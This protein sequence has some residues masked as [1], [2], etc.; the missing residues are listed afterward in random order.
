MKANLE[1][2]Y[3]RI[4]NQIIDKLCSINLSSYENRVL[5]CVIRKTYGF[6]KKEDWIANSQ[7]VKQTSIHKAHVSRAIKKLK[8]R[9]IVT[10]T[11]NLLKIN[12]DT[13]SW[14]PNQVTKKKLPKEATPLPNQVTPVTS[15]GY[16]KL[17]KEADTKD[18]KDTIT[19]DTIQKTGDSLQKY[20]DSFNVFF[21]REFKTTKGR[22]T[23]LRTRLKAFSLEEIL[24]AVENLS[25]SPWHRGIN[26]SGWT[27]S[28]DFIIRSDE[29]VD[30]WLNK[31]IEQARQLSKINKQKEQN[32]KSTIAY[33][34]E[35]PTT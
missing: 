8:D 16:K 26:P 13:S 24:T 5:M 29:K 25:K 20:I 1:D 6:N 17:P 27:A 10:Q 31:D 34:Q 21:K 22:E 30:E 32:D 4:S 18:N 15:I 19:K 23:K 28:P 3:A 12:T 11:G 2:G 33:Y 14:L 9:Q 7:I 35:K